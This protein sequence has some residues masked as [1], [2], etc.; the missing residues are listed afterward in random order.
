MTDKHIQ[1]F[2]SPLGGDL[3]VLT[4]DDGSLHFVAADVAKSLG[5]RD[6]AN[7]VRMVADYE[8][9]T[10]AVSTT[11]GPQQM[12]TITESGLYTAALRSRR[13]EAEPFK[14]WVTEEVLPTIRRTGGAY[15]APGSEAEIVLRG[16]PYGGLDTLI[17]TATALRDERNRR[18]KLQAENAVLVPKANL[19]DEW[20]ASDSGVHIVEFAN[21]HGM[22]Q[23][24]M[25]KALRDLGVLFKQRADGGSG[26]S[27][28]AAKVGYKH[29]FR[30]IREQ[31]PSGEF[32]PVLLV[33]PEGEVTLTR[34]LTAAGY[35]T[36]E[37]DDD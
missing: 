11:N 26:K 8:K 17:E 22:T 29:L 31:I 7:M 14:R 18:A 21:K 30:S 2:T 19:H 9:G 37:G 5:Y 4:A 27:F 15:V 36:K 25:Y 28:N 12:T 32:V 20:Q 13:P 16:D 24:A 10:H 23:P 33:T 3:R 1:Q 6:A 35:I 34:I